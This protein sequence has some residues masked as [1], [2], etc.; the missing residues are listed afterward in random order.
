VCL[1]ICLSELFRL[2]FLQAYALQSIIIYGLFEE[3][4]FNYHYCAYCWP[5]YILQVFTSTF[6]A[7]AWT[8]LGILLCSVT[9]AF[10][11]NSDGDL[12]LSMRAL[13]A[14]FL[15]LDIGLSKIA[16]FKACWRANFT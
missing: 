3:Q 4:K 13:S 11:S 7:F 6:S 15:R 1:S 5:T 2:I 14:R 10:H 16:V 12:P 9:P 8:L